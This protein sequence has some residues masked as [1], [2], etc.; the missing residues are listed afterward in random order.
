[1][2]EN[3]SAAQM[4]TRRLAFR[5]TSRTWRDRKTPE[6]HGCLLFYSVHLSVHTG[7]IARELYNSMTSWSEAQPRW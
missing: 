6:G 2:M 7:S 3:L 4:T 5:P 1:M